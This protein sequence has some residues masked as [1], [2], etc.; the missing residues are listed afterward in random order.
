MKPEDEMPAMGGLVLACHH[1]QK[2]WRWAITTEAGLRRF[3]RYGPKCSD[4]L[5]KVI[6]EYGRDDKRELG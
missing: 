6:D 3:H 5:A 4:C 1:C 2:L